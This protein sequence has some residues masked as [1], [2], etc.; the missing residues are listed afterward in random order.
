MKSSARSASG[1]RELGD[2]SSIGGEVAAA[3]LVGSVRGVGGEA[4]G[5]PGHLVCLLRVSL[6]AYPSLPSCRPHRWRLPHAWR[7]R[8]AERAL[9]EPLWRSVTGASVAAPRRMA[10][11][12]WTKPRLAG[13]SGRRQVTPGMQVG[14]GLAVSGVAKRSGED[15]RPHAMAQVSL[16]RRPP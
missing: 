4:Y 1:V 3:F 2:R 8:R 7:G 5:G 11:E 14:G 15:G 12:V 9:L 6:Y 10:T 13:Y 16:G